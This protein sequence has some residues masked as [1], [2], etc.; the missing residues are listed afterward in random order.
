MDAPVDKTMIFQKKIMGMYLGAFK[1]TEDAFLLNKS[2]HTE[3]L[4][5]P[6]TVNQ[7]PIDCSTIV[8]RLPVSDCAGSWRGDNGDVSWGS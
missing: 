5:C 4:D 7:R 3:F 1:A 2:K 6:S 8:D